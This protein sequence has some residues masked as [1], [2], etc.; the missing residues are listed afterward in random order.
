MSEWQPP[1]EQ[2][3]QPQYQPYQQPTYAP[4][5][6][7]APPAHPSEADRG[8]RPGTVTAAA[9]LTWVG[10]ALAAVGSVLLAALSGA[11]AFLDSFLQETDGQFT[12]GEAQGL[13]VGVGVVG[14]VWSVIA[15]VLAVLT[16]KRH[17]W[18]RIV[19]TVSAVMA[20]MTSLVLILSFFSVVTL[21]LAVAA[22]VLLYVGGAND[23]FAHR[24][25]QQHQ[26]QGP[27]PTYYG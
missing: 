2:P 27:A 16:V 11:D 5:A 24:T 1:P 10:C 9:V 21:V 15:S 20:A 4:P 19:L 25:G 17:G 23:W 12:R 8:K 18:A 26:Q 13:L 3:Q 6:Y 14:F 22:V 7:G